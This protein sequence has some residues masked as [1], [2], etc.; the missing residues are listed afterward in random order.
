MHGTVMILSFRTDRSGQTVQTQIRLLLGA[1]WSGSA[2]FA[3]DPDQTR[4]SLIRIYTICHSVC[5]LDALL[6]G[7]AALFKF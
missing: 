5:I 4:S 2:L 1:V 7:K 3:A 6:Y